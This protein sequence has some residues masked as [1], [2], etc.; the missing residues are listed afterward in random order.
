MSVSPGGL[1]AFE[2]QPFENI[3]KWRD[4]SGDAKLHW[5]ALTT[6]WFAIRANGQSLMRYA[7]WKSDELANNPDYQAEFRT[8][9]TIFDPICEL[10]GPESLWQSVT[11]PI[12]EDLAAWHA[13]SRASENF[14][15]LVAR[16]DSAFDQNEPLP[17]AARDVFP[18]W[19]EVLKC[20][21][22]VRPHAV[23]FGWELDMPTFHFLVTETNARMWWHGHKPDNADAARP[24]CDIGPGSLT[25]PR[26]ELRSELVW[27]EQT[28]FETMS[29]RIDA[30]AKW[31]PQPRV[32]ADITQIRAEHVAAQQKFASDR[33]LC[34]A[35]QPD[36]N[37]VRI[38]IDVAQTLDS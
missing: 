36:W 31:Y 23:W 34:D 38:A 35:R 24:L 1:F 13:T 21:W 32:V 10:L 22:R 19:T 33:A 3:N 6:G 28:F 17:T 14:E 8:A 18:T 9:Y 11:H 16:I 5:Y 7:K 15:Q 27:L 2:F 26:G 20:L 30:F 4:A 12:P 25:I 37:R 29:R